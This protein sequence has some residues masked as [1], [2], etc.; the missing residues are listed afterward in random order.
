M[1][2]F[3]PT[4]YILNSPVSTLCFEEQIMLILRWAKNRES[5]NVFLAN[6]HMI[7]EAYWNQN[8]ARVLQGSDLVSPDGM[9]LV[10]MLRCLGIYNQNRVAG[11]D[12]FLNLCEL[13]QHNKVGVFFVGSQTAVLEKIKQRLDKEFPILSVFGAEALPFKPLTRY[14]DDILVDKINQ[15]KAG[16]VFVCLGCPKQEFWIAQHKHKIRAVMIGIGAVFPTYAG[17]YRRA[18][19][20]IRELGLE[21]LHRL[22][23]EPR[24]LWKRYSKTIPPFIY[25]ALKQLFT[26]AKSGLY[27]NLA[28]YSQMIP[29]DDKVIS[30]LSVEAESSKIGQI[31]LRQNLVTQE[32]L[33][34]ALKEQIKYPQLKLGEILLEHKCI[35]LPELRYYLRNQKITL[36]EILID[37]KILVPG[38]LNKLLEK[39]KNSGR[40]LGE[41]LLEEKIISRDQLQL[42]SLEQYWRRKGW[43]LTFEGVRESYN[44][45]AE[46]RESQKKS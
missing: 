46:L 2:I 39:T 26:S 19:Y 40:K 37:K 3:I 16:L 18:P 43:W 10:W 20:Y 6:V 23:Q 21:W 9:P 11:M 36:G 41:I 17:I 24:R 1:E 25:L 33:T 12:V 7:M 38:K 35:S 22:S 30:N 29:Q 8:F 44:S 13:A 34:K 14:E 5:R 45:H 15:S 42:I 28:E 32:C 4:T 31:L 27:S